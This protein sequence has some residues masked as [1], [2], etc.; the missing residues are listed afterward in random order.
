MKA[1]IWIAGLFIMVFVKVLI[2]RNL[3]LGA[4]GETLYWSVWF[5]GAPLLCK[6]WEKHKAK[7]KGLEQNKNNEA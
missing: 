7:Q 2:L 4:I 5:L 1:A 6:K 3:F